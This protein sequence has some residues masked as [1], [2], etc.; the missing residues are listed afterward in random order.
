MKIAKLDF[1]YGDQV[2][3]VDFVKGIT[4]EM[5]VSKLFQTTHDEI[6][7]QAKSLQAIIL[8]KFHKN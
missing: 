7:I 5:S 1:E 4:P 6:I 8:N 3:P 2:N